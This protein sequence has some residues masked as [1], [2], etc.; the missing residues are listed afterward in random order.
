MAAAAARVG[1]STGVAMVDHC[2]GASRSAMRRVRRERHSAMQVLHAPLAAAAEGQCSAGSC[3]CSA[4]ALEVQTARREA[5]THMDT[6]LRDCDG[7][8]RGEQRRRAARAHAA[9]DQ[10]HDVSG[11]ATKRMD[12][13]ACSAQLARCA[14]YTH[15]PPVT[16][17]HAQQA[18]N[19]R[20]KGCWLQR[21][22]EMIAC[23]T[24]AKSCCCMPTQQVALP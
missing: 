3:A 5:L 22:L 12:G 8:I 13:C 4:Q 19:P 14:C 21:K 7:G 16:Q 9:C 20:A 18:F 24:G 23:A 6:W 17:Q 1:T 2:R 15:A 10:C 11:L